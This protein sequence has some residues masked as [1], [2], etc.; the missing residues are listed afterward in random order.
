MSTKV[1]SASFLDPALN[2]IKTNAN[3]MVLCSAEPTT[4]T[5]AVDNYALANV[6]LASGDFSGPSNGFASGRKLIVA[7][8][9]GVTVVA[10]GTARYLALVNTT[11]SSLLYVAPIAERA[12]TIASTITIGSFVLELRDAF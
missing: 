4:Y 3:K 1:W 2:Y 7:A 10:S 5:Q 9:T 12:L 8:K 6:A 11:S